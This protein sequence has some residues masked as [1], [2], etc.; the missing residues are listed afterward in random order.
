MNTAFI[1]SDTYLL[2]VT[3]ATMC[4]NSYK[5]TDSIDTS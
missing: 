1:R 2:T 5:K 3:S 4:Q